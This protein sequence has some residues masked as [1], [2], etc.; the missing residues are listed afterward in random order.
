[1]TEDR[2][3]AGLRWSYHIDD[4]DTKGFVFRATVA[5]LERWDPKT[6]RWESLSHLGLS[7]QI[8]TGGGNG[9]WTFITEAKALELMTGR[10]SPA[11]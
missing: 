6:R 1:M 9:S 8:F 3:P 7:E 5:E 11:A 2:S 10:P 4:N